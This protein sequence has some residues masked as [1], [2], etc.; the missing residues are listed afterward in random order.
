MSDDGGTTWYPAYAT[1]QNAAPPT[2][3]VN[4]FTL[5]GSNTIWQI[6]V[7]GYTNFRIRL[8]PVITGAGTANVRWLASA[9]PTRPWANAQENLVQVGG[10]P[11]VTGTGISGAGVPRVTVSSD[12]SLAANQS[13]NLNQISGSPLVTGTGVSGAGVPRV[14][15][16]S[17]SSLAANQSVNI[18][19]LN[20]TT[21]VTGGI[22]GSQASGG[23]GANNAA[24]T[25]NP[26]L[27]GAEAVATAANPTAATAG[28]LRRAISDVAGNVFVRNGGPN[29]FNC[30]LTISTATTTQCQA[31]P[32]AGFSLYVTHVELVTTT[33]GTGST[34]QLKYGTG[35]NCGTGT[36]SASPTYANTAAGNVFID[37]GQ[38]AITTP[39][40]NAVCITQAGT[41]GT[42]QVLV[43]GFIA[44]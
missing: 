20:G 31:A 21:Q 4:T 36:T 38:S 18:T 3:P 9:L 33:A 14:T 6:D 41:A 23:T 30:Q 12:S 44:P 2:T 26:D 40:A 5:T 43:A 28:N 39:A 7:A 17:D 25:Q 37:F 11:V 13:V 27:I 10:A 32:P 24:I 15:I 8:N 16:S 35:S 29:L 19:Q 34:L 42:T 22:A 1:Q